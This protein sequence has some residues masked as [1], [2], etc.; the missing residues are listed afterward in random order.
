MTN[1]PTVKWLD[2]DAL[3]TI[4]PATADFE[5]WERIVALA[6]LRDKI[7]LGEQVLGVVFTKAREQNADMQILWSEVTTRTD[8]LSSDVTT[9]ASATGLNYVTPVALQDE[10]ALTRI[11]GALAILRKVGCSATDGIAYAKPQQTEQQARSIVQTVKSKYDT[12]LWQTVARPLRNILRD[13]QRKSLVS[14]MLTHPLTGVKPI[15]RNSNDLYAYYLMD[16]EMEPCQL[17]SR[18]KQVISVT[19]LF[20]Q[21]CLMNLED[22]VKA[23]AE[24]DSRWEEWKTLKNFRVASAGRQV[25]EKPENFLDGSIRDDKTIFFKELETDLQQND[26]TKDIAETA[27]IHYLEKL[28]QVANLE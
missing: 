26:L 19:Q 20:V 2:F 8:W 13:E 5:G 25:F 10:V 23:N 9:I 21:R 16:V 11:Q 1:D 28:D 24:Y 14:Y 4:V 3:P 27:L 15:W 12:A 7:P 6:A 22:G 18:I 17:T